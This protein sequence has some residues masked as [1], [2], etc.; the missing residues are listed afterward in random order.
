MWHCNVLSHKALPQLPQCLAS[1][2]SPLT[3]ICTSLNDTP[4]LQGA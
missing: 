4:P 3:N 1:K 2:G